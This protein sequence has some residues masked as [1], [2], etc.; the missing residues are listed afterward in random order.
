VKICWFLVLLLKGEVGEVLTWWEGSPTFPPRPRPEG[1]R[2][3]EEEPV[4]LLLEDVGVEEVSVVFCC[5]CGGEG[6]VGEGGRCVGVSVVVIGVFVVGVVEVCVLVGVVVVV[7]GVEGGV[8]VVI[9][10]RLC[11]LVKSL[12]GGDGVRDRLVGVSR[13]RGVVAFRTT[14]LTGIRRNAGATVK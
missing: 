3:G 8:A 9:D 7:E 12:G 2:G 4:L 10:L 1:S 13:V 14:L 11:L 5:L 6:E